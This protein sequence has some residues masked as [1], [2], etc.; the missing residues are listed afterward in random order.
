[1]PTPCGTPL[2]RWV[3]V[4][5][6]PV[7]PPPVNV[8]VPA[9]VPVPPLPLLWTPGTVPPG[10]VPGRAPLGATVLPLDGTPSPWLPLPAALLPRPCTVD[11]Q[12]ASSSTAAV[13]PSGPCKRRIL[14][15]RPNRVLHSGSE[16]A[17]EVH[18]GDATAV[19]AGEV[20]A[21]ALGRTVRDDVLIAV[22]GDD[23]EREH[24]L[25]LGHL[26]ALLPQGRGHL[27]L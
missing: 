27:G 5:D 13:A 25:L 21:H 18:T 22:A 4:A 11:P 3:P 14:I 7:D 2:T 6:P 15:S 23:G 16:P 1:M 10:A 12:P 8:P 17:A 26:F 19:V 24:R 9:P 20:A